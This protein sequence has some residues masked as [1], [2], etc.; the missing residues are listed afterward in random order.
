[1]KGGLLFILIVI[2]L[3]VPVTSLIAVEN[4]QTT[5][6]PA[7]IDVFDY[8]LIMGNTAR[9]KAISN[10]Q[11]KIEIFARGLTGTLSRDL[12]KLNTCDNT[13]ICEYPLPLPVP[14]ALS[15]SGSQAEYYAELTVN[16]PF[17]FVH[18]VTKH[19][20]IGDQGNTNNYCKDERTIV[21]NGAANSPGQVCSAAGQGQCNP[22][23][24]SRSYSGTG[25]V[26]CFYPNNCINNDALQTAVSCPPP[27]TSPGTIVPPVGP[28]ETTAT[29]QTR[30]DVFDYSL[31]VNKIA[32]IKA[33]ANKPGRISIFVEGLGPNA[34]KVCNDATECSYLSGSENP[35]YPNGVNLPIHYAGTTVRYYAE[36]VTSTGERISSSI[37]E[38]RI[39]DQ[40]YQNNFCADENS[41][42]LYGGANTPGARCTYAQSG[43]CNPGYCKRTSPNQVVCDYPNNCVNN[44]ALRTL[45]P[46]CQG[47]LVRAATVDGGSVS[48]VSP[49]GTAQVANQ[50]I[51]LRQQPVTTQGTLSFSMNLN[52]PD[53]SASPAQ[54]SSGDALIWNFR[55]NN[56]GPSFNTDVCFF[57]KDS[58]NNYHDIT[59]IIVDKA[60]EQYCN[61]INPQ[62]EY[63]SIRLNNRQIGTTNQEVTGQIVTYTFPNTWGA[64]TYQLTAQLRNPNVGCSN[65]DGSIINSVPIATSTN[66]FTYTRN[67]GGGVTQPPAQQPTTPT[68]PSTIN[69]PSNNLEWIR[70]TPDTGPLGTIFVLNAKFSNRL[71]GS[72][73]IAVVQ[74]DGRDIAT[75]NLFNDG[76]HGDE[77][78]NDN[79]YGNTWDSSG[80][81]LGR[82]SILIL[83]GNSR[84]NDILKEFSILGNN[85]V[86]VFKGGD[87]NE[88]IDI[89]FASRGFADSTD[90]RNQ[91]EMHAGLR[92]GID[93][94]NDGLFNVEPFK[95]N[96]HK[97]NVYLVNQLLD[98]RSAAGNLYLQCPT[99]FSMLLDRNNFRSTVGHVSIVNDRGTSG[100]IRTTVHELGHAIGELADEYVEDGRSSPLVTINGRNCFSVAPIMPDRFDC[101]LRTCFSNDGCLANCNPPD[102][103]CLGRISCLSGDGCAV[104]CTPIDPDCGNGASCNNFD[105]CLANCNPP[106]PD[107]MRGGLARC[108]SDESCVFGCTPPDNDC[109]TLCRSGNVCQV[110][111][112]PIDPDCGNGASCNQGD[113]CAGGSCFRAFG[114]EQCISNARWKELIGNSC[115]EEGVIDCEP[116]RDPN[117]NLEINCIEGCNYALENIFRPAYN[118]IMRYHYIN[119][120]SFGQANEKAL[121]QNIKSRTGS[122]EGICTRYRL[123]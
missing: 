2:F 35:A 22:G 111:C 94:S 34:L 112:T 17:E 30:I 45:I 29:C 6:C 25:D 15:L 84:R 113:G 123:E 95:S 51:G 120:Y 105:G 33:I 108:G 63:C 18:S 97:F 49:S 121:C 115:N 38:A 101:A 73:P 13:M 68:I 78:P 60:N 21:L 62:P 58:N 85:C 5:S 72:N 110:G 109:E 83:I 53:S 90:F 64:G 119:P 106:D 122:A 104:G 103:D 16:N 80:Q 55:L 54:Y 77:G 75:V 23:Y 43:Q 40:L 57:L 87:M 76:A 39:G 59:R 99:D 86:E 81:P 92:L 27:T 82:Y 11:G 19:G 100:Y 50:N 117:Y 71:E 56:Q 79:I 69:N 8:G 89:T 66:Y 107:C 32:R 12:V 116:F 31:I 74:K 88:K 20:V 7:K 67:T 118:T 10:K 9:I 47:S 114:R 48:Q 36:L 91:V 37:K 3:I 26:G 46:M 65:P 70:T 44:D 96:K 41:I 61:N 93:G 28:G 52:R 24:C 1:M 14:D 42:V 102:P 98:D 4:V